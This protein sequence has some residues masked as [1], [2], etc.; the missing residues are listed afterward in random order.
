MSEYVQLFGFTV[1]LTEQV[2]PEYE[3]HITFDDNMTLTS[4]LTAHTAQQLYVSSAQ[5]SQSPEVAPCATTMNPSIKINLAYTKLF[6]VDEYLQT[7]NILNIIE[8]PFLL[9]FL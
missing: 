5:Y 4:M 6:L 9:F 1:E 2:V 3:A 8:Y 7:K